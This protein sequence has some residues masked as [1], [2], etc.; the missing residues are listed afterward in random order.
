[1]INPKF[2]GA[3]AVLALGSNA[4]FA[5]VTANGSVTNNYLW[6]GL[7]Q[8][9]NEA[10]VQ[11]GIDWADESGFYLGTWVSNV[12]YAS[13]DGYS[14]EHD[15]YFGWSGGDDVT[16]DVGYLY[17]N[18]DDSQKFDFAEIYGTV[19]VGGFSASL[20]LLANTEADEPTGYDFGFGQ[21]Y[22][23]SL[24]YGFETEKGLGIGFHVGQHDGDFVDGFNGIAVNGD[25]SYMDYSVTFSVDAF[26]FTISDTDLPDT[27]CF[28]CGGYLDNGEMKFVASYGME[29]GL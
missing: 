6:R 29:F 20:Y 9:N 23:L 24:D 4:A 18:Y 12:E 25:T 15:F 17:Y 26:S 5:E 1:M 22:Y 21:A 10:A 11:G 28:A 13:D 14:Y 19:G 3:A 7:T 16:Y 2:L 27:G 8:S